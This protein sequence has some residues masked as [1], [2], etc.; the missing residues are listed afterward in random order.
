MKKR[1]WIIAVVV[2]VV[3]CLAY[4][5]ISAWRGVSARRA[6]AQAAGAETAVVR[7]G[8][9]QVTVGG[10]GS[11]SPEDAVSLAFQSG[12]QVAEV[13]VAV[14]DVVRA[15]D[16]LARLDDASARQAVAQA[17]LAVQQAQVNL[18]S[19]RVEAEAGLAQANL[20]AAQASYAEA[21]AM[22]AHTGDQLTSASVSLAQAEDQLTTAQENYDQ[23]WD[24]ARDWELNVPFRKTALENERDA[25]RRALQ[26]AQ[27][28]LQVAQAAYN[29][30]V[31]GVSDN[32]VL[33]ARAQVVN[34]Q[35]SVDKQPLQIQQLEIALSQAQLQLEAAQRTLAEATLVAPVAGTVTAL[36]VKAGEMAGGG[37]AAVVLSDLTTL[38]VGINLDETDVANASVGQEAIVTLDA[39]PNAEITGTVASIAP[40]AQVQS[41]VVLYPVTVRLSP[42]DPSAGSGQRLPVRAGMTADA[43]IV[44]ASRENV[45]IVPLRAVQS[46]NG[47]A[48]VLRQVTGGQ[49]GPSGRPGTV[50]GFERVPVTL[51]LM[52]DTDVEITSGLSEGD[53]VSVTATPAQ[54][55]GGGFGPF[56]FFGGG[57]G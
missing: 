44:T 13:P 15:G 26:S 21:S 14:G 7:R 38:V 18:D 45:L 40:V 43:Q 16:V 32:S 36:N 47:Q 55:G 48:F 35:V 30:A 25:T 51:G 5:G 46:A 6:A 10:S 34:A 39:F 11:L 52:N 29:L 27:Y 4:A 17:Q 8:T 53:V 22:A 41:G 56:R 20:D 28:N 37:S 50:G 2:V 23:A 1:W 12:G 54:G 57:G 9:L 42:T 19:A 31:A 33:N 3:G 49:G 24:P